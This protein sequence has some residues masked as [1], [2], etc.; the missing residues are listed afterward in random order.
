MF[1]YK[2]NSFLQRPS[3]ELNLDVADEYVGESLDINENDIAE[4]LFTTG[5]TS[6]PKGVCLSYYNIYSSATNINEYID[7]S[8]EDIE[9]LALPICHSFGM[10]GEP[11]VILIKVATIVILSNF[12]N[13]RAFLKAFEKYH[14]TG[15]GVV[16]AAWA[17]IRKMSGNRIAKY[18]EQVHYIETMCQCQ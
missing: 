4:I 9:L 6:A 8:E 5:T 12:A 16:P 3:V 2:S 15:F 10:E 18:A 17:Y 11:A 13:V 14:I 7:N 1:G